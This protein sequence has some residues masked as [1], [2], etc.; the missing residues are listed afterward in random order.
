[1]YE[2]VCYIIRYKINGTNKWKILI[3]IG[4]ERIQH[5]HKKIVI[6]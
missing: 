4:Q 2:I 3:K 6:E 5:T 1:M